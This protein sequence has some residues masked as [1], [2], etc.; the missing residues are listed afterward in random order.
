LSYWLL[1][2]LVDDRV[3]SR[4]LA[5]PLRGLG[6]SV[7]LVRLPYA[8]V[9]FNGRGVGGAAVLVGV[10]LKNLSDLCSSLRTGRLAGHQNPGLSGTYDHR[11]LVVEGR[12]G[13]D[14]QGAITSFK[15]GRSRALHGQMTLAEVE[16]RLLT[17]ELATGLHVRHT[18]GRWQTLRFIQCL[19]RWWTDKAQDAHKSHLVPHVLPSLIPMSTFRRVVGQLPGVGP[20]ASKA[21]EARFGT[22]ARAC[23]APVQEWAALDVGGR[24]LG[25][26]QAEAIV[27]FLREG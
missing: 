14:R 16:G 19:Y 8:D 20:A 18:G 25:M 12:Y 13:S 21:A 9:A 17:L 27:R 24:K 11:W 6:L 1:M 7:E 22:L 4:D 23:Q 26:K 2:L 15:R 3:G 5:T 10:E